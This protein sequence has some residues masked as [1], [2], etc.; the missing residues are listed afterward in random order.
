LPY[1][2][3]AEAIAEKFHADVDYLA[4]LN[5]GKKAEIKAGDVLKVPNVE[6]FD[7]PR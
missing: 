3:A 4:E 7:S 2:S 6:P 5:P 1:K